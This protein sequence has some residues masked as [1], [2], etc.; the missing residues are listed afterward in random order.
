[1][2]QPQEKV[3][4]RFTLK[5]LTAVFALGCGPAMANSDHGQWTGSEPSYGSVTTQSQT[6]T[7]ATPSTPTWSNGQQFAPPQTSPVP[8]PPT[9]QASP[10][11]PQSDQNQWQDQDQDED[12]TD[13]AADASGQRHLGVLVMSLTPE[14]QRFFGVTNGRGVLIARVEPGSPA[15]HAGV[16]VGDVLVRVGQRP[17]HSGDD[18]VQALAAHNGGRIR[19][20]VIRQGRPLRLDATM[21]GAQIQTPDQ[22]DL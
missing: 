5:L 22:N 18:V 17:V 8:P 13:N 16:Q 15:E 4:T 19:V 14:L 10:S 9:P 1:L 7:S 3:M 11:P 20:A 2:L 6:T 12:T 21:P